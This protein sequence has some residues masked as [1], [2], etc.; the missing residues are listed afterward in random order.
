MSTARRRRLTRSRDDRVVAGVCGG[1]AEY[2]G[3]DVTIVRV[4]FLASMLLP[5]PQIL[6]Y[7]AAWIIMPN[8]DRGDYGL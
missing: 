8:P 7:L 5:G 2:L 1:L 4:L 3:I 6:L